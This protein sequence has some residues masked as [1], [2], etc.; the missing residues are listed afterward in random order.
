MKPRERF[1]AAASGRPVD[2]PPVWVMRQ[3]G[4]Y[5]PEYRAVKERHSFQEMCRTPELAAEVTLQPLR[6]FPLDAAILFSDILVIPE[7]LGVGVEYREGGPVLSRALRRPD[8]LATLETTGLMERLAFVPAA[9]QAIRASLGAD[10]AL[11]GFAGAP[12]TLAVYM[13]EGGASKQFLETKRLLYAQPAVLHALLARLTD[14]VIPYLLAQAEAGADAVQLFDTWAGELAPAVF[15]AFTL[16]YVQRIAEALR[17]A[18]VPLIYYINGAAGLLDAMAES[19]A[20]VL[21]VDWRCELASVAMR[22]RLPLQGNLDPFLLFAPEAAI[23]AEVRRVHES[24]AGHP[25]LF[26]LG[27]GI[28]PQAPLTGMDAF[29]RAVTRLNEA[30]A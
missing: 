9:L 30:P 25:H 17:E 19:G 27:H 16:P 14:A 26:N 3:A 12:F 13:I 7:A 22:T 10:R 29:V 24:L 28:F 1:L 21:G 6:R 5:L 8:D 23:E 18:G 2:R 11:L 4:R 20:S 15:R